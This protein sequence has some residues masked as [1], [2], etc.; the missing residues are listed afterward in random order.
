M[1][2][3]LRV[4]TPLFFLFLLVPI[5]GSAQGIDQIA[6]F[7]DSLSDPGNHFIFFR[8]SSR[9][10]FSVGPPD[11]S[12]DIGGHHFSNGNTWA[13]QLATALHLPTSGNPALRA[14]GRFTNY[15]IGQARARAAAPTFPAFDLQTQVESYLADFGGHVPSGTLAA[16]WIGGN[17]VDDALN[18]LLADP[19]GTTSGA[20]LQASLAATRDAI[21]LL[22]GAGAR[23]FLIA[24]IPDFAYTPYVRFL[25]A[26]AYPGIAAAATTMTGLYNSW[27]SDLVGALP[28]LL[29]PDPVQPLLFIRLLDTNAIIGQIVASPSLFGIVDA[30][31]RCTT[32]DVTGHALC[33]TPKRYLFW[34]G[35]HPTT[36]GHNA[37]A[38]AA[39]QRLPPQ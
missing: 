11:A 7:G 34:D 3:F 39:I 25:D 32:P 4:A 31:N 23:M 1:R 27:I 15:A 9:Q 14:P 17:D 36:T 35:I 16:I 38:E 12:Y 19:T 18:A 5:A 10:P 30:S 33:S 13:E 28:F 24:N 22:Y 6:F 2:T 29:P 37:V 26:T 21:L 20:I 8:V